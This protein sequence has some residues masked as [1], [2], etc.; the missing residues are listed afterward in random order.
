VR[1]STLSSSNQLA[2][3]NIRNP[4][5]A[6]R[7]VFSTSRGKILLGYIGL[8]FSSCIIVAA[9][10][11]MEISSILIIVP[12]SLSMLILPGYELLHLICREG[13]GLTTV[14]R[15]LLS[16]ILSILTAASGYLL[17]TAFHI[18]ARTSFALFSAVS[19]TLF[20]LGAR[21]RC[22]DCEEENQRRPN[23]HVLSILLV[24]FLLSLSWRLFY[25]VKAYPLFLGW[26]TPRYVAESKWFVEGVPI[27]YSNGVPFGQYP[28]VYMMGA[29]FY[30]LFGIPHIVPILASIIDSLSIFSLYVLFK[31]IIDDDRAVLA[32]V[33]LCNLSFFSVR[34]YSDLYADL[35]VNFL[36]PLGIYF[37]ID[38]HE[39]KD[40]HRIMLAGIIFGLAVNTHSQAPYRIVFYVFFYFVAALILRS[41]RRML[42]K[43][44]LIIAAILVASFIPYQTYLTV[45]GSEL[46]VIKNLS[47]G[48]S[49]YLTPA[50]TQKTDLLWTIPS[51]TR[52]LVN[53]GVGLSLGSAL[54]LIRGKRKS[55]LWFL[56]CTSAL[57]FIFELP[58]LG[59][60]YPLSERVFDYYGAFSFLL[61]SVAVFFIV[62]LLIWCIRAGK[63]RIH[64]KGLFVIR[65][66]KIK[67]HSTRLSIAIV[68]CLL[69][70]SALLLPIDEFAFCF[71]RTEVPGLETP[72]SSRLEPVI[73]LEQYNA[74]TSVRDRSTT[75]DVVI[76]NP[77]LWGYTMFLFWGIRVTVYER[78]A[79][80]N[81]T[82]QEMAYGLVWRTGFPDALEYFSTNWINVWVI[83]S[84]NYDSQSRQLVTE[85]KS[86]P[87]FHQVLQNEEIAV[88][89]IDVRETEVAF[90]NILSEAFV[91]LIHDGHVSQEQL[92]FVRYSQGKIYM[93]LTLTGS[94]EYNVTNIPA[95]LSFDSISPE[96]YRMDVNT[97]RSIDL[98][99]QL[100]TNYTLTFASIFP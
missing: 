80:T 51:P 34:F 50:S 99:G 15:L 97:N 11:S 52:L 25:V 92:A 31:K 100:G 54:L 84:R 79:P 35:F 24:I 74:L 70:I 7:L 46:S 37:L 75:H 71:V 14:E 33:L 73:T 43:S 57:I 60:F 64:W 30:S 19:S 23:R 96:P 61:K 53:E 5:A 49:S 1:S 63:L 90:E 27:R 32:A 6:L 67:L 12:C 41:E 3:K 29:I 78:V 93:T 10:F 9:P 87:L 2:R 48:A 82:D 94:K 83:L 40:L 16:V 20:Y 38:G 22:R 66:T 98:Q 17:L 77:H 85:L 28:L 21:R 95:F 81:V 26:D 36:L 72:W 76:V 56:L 13:K 8:V 42:L 62:D 89:C 86:D 58:Y 44:T 69:L 4:I 59:Y 68:T 45:M 65:V 88:F 91:S 47:L 39:K 18:L 55:A